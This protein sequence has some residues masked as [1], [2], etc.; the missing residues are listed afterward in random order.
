MKLGIDEA[1]KGCIIG[2]LVMGAVLIDPEKE[3]LLKSI[4]VKDSKLLTPEKREEL[5]EQV[6]SIADRFE[7]VEISPRDIDLAVFAT[8]L[9][10]LEADH[11]AR[12]I[13]L[14]KP[15]HVV[16]DCPSPNIRAFKEYVFER[17]D[18]KEILITCEHKA[19]VNHVVVGAASILAKV[20]RDRAIENIKNK[21]GCDFGS[22]YLTDEKT[23]EFLKK[24]YKKYAYLFRQSWK[25]YKKIIEGIHQK[26]LGDF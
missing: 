2:P 14:M 7:I 10:W 24:H 21:I 9:N 5:F 11:Q 13:N 17:I 15:T 22:G 4:G 18:H 20:T 23:Q 19:D 6:K 12:F 3:A 8:N 26:S 16:I 25:P 1:G